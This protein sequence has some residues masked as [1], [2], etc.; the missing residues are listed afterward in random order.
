[1]NKEK[2]KKVTRGR[3]LQEET[4]LLVQ[5]PETDETDRDQPLQRLLIYVIWPEFNTQKDTMTDIF[6]K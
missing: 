5:S 6:S 1:M 2:R 4:T 3:S